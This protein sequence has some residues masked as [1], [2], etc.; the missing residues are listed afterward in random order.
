LGVHTKWRPR[1]GFDCCAC[2][3]SFGAILKSRSIILCVADL[4]TY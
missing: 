4:V 2:F 3:V 1:G